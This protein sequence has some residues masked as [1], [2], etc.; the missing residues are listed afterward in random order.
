MAVTALSALRKTQ[1]ATE[2]YE[3]QAAQPHTRTTRAQRFPFVSIAN[4]L[5]D[6]TN[7]GGVTFHVKADNPVAQWAGTKGV[8]TKMGPRL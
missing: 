5:E 1:Q 6:I 7:H 2:S 4:Q 8:T 3:S